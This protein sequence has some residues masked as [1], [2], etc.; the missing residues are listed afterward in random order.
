MAKAKSIVLKR[1]VDFQVLGQRVLLSPIATKLEEVTESGIILDQA[2]I[3]ELKKA[4]SKILMMG[5]IVNIGEEVTKVAE[6]D[7]VYVYPN[8]FEADIVI[9]G[10]TYLIYPERVLMGKVK[11]HNDGQ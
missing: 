2:S 6:G 11:N 1:K 10:M 8:Q 3:M 4:Q 9:D 7:V 5:E